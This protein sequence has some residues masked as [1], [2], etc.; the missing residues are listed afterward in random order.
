M[1]GFDSDLSFVPKLDVFD[2]YSKLKWNVLYHSYNS[3]ST[4][5]RSSEYQNLL[6]EW[7]GTKY[8]ISSGFLSSSIL[9]NSFS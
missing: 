9:L 4:T 5:S 3:L 7:H 8:I 2:M 1:D 6:P